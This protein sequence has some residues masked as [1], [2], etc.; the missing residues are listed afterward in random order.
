MK[1]IKSQPSFKKGIYFD[2]AATTPVDPR[3]FHAMQPYFS[4]LF[5]NPGSL[6]KRGQE[7]SAAVFEA[8]RKIAAHVGADT[9][10]LIFTG[11]ATEANNLILRGVLKGKKKKN[12][13]ITGIEHES[14]IETVHDLEK[15][16]ITIQVIPVSRDGVIDLEKFKKALNKDTILVSVMYVNNEIGTIQPIK[17][18]ANIIKEFKQLKYR[19]KS[20]IQNPN[21]EVEYP[22]LHTDAVQALQYLDCNVNTFAV[23]AM[24]LSAHKLYG[25]KGVGALYL[26]NLNFEFRT[27]NSLLIQPMITGG[28]QEDGMRSGTENVPNIVGFGKAVELFAGDNKETQR[29]TA[30]RD[31]FWETLSHEI[32]RMT[33]HGPAPNKKNIRI[34]NN[35]HVAFPKISSQDMLVAL[36]MHGISASA[37]PACGA[38]ARKI[39]HVLEAI[40]LKKEESERS[41]RF[42]MGRQTTKAHIDTSLRVIKNIVR[43]S[44]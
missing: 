1:K 38:R 41:I 44:I 17:E 43:E 10:N 28:G 8:R 26:R 42:T 3:V 5:G 40:G 23:D 18:I 20:E 16:G 35:I 33:L 25:P 13:I 34:S 30:L 24:T 31:Y 19:S 29:I 7:A 36:D 39:S 9:Q 14:I 22:L 4:H 2:Y 6:H 15:D 37:G 27:S 32:P 11:S 12:I 21:L